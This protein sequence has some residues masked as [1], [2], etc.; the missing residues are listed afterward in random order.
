MAMRDTAIV[1][2]AETR[3]VQRSDGDIWELGAE[4]LEA[5]LDKTGI[6]KGEIDGLVLSGSQTGAGNP[7]WSQTTADQLALE[8]DINP[9]IAHPRGEGVT[10]LDALIITADHAHDIHCGA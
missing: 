1:A 4:V 6:E 10:A 7:F 2:Y 5:L 8:V 9:L 3:I